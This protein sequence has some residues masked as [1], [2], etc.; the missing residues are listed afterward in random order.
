MRSDTIGTILFTGGSAN[1]NRTTGG[2]ANT[3]QLELSRRTSHLSKYVS[4]IYVPNGYVEPCHEPLQKRKRC[5]AKERKSR[6]KKSGL[7]LSP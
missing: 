5:P 2:S 7:A 3:K 6:V 4:N 1:T